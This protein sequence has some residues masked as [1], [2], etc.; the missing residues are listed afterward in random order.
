MPKI[1]PQ[2]VS[3]TPASGTFTLNAQTAIR[4]PAGQEEIRR[5]GQYLSDRL[6]PATGFPLP[7]KAISGRSASGQILLTTDHADPALGDEGYELSV[8]RGSVR[9]SAPQP[10]GL[11]HGVQTLRQLFPAS[12]ESPEPAAG[13]WML[14]AC[15]VR[16]RPRFGWRGAMLDVA[17]HFFDPAAVRRFIDQMAYYKL[18]LLHLHLSDDQG[19]RLEIQSH[20]DLAVKGGACSV[21]FESNGYY[22]QAEY[23]DLVEYARQRYITILPEIDMPGHTNAVLAA[24]PEL[25]PD[26]KAPEPYPGTEVGFSS[27]AIHQENTYAFLEDVIRELAALTPG[28]YLHIGGDEAHS[29]PEPDYIHFVQRVQQIVKAHGKMCIGWEEVAKAELLPDTVVQFW[30]NKDWARKG[31]EQGRKFMLSPATHAYMDI[32][33]DAETLLGQDWTKVYIPVKAAYEW[34]P[35]KMLEGVGEKSILGVEAPLWSETTVTTADLDYMIFPRL[36]GYAEIAWSPKGPR[37][38]EEYRQ[39]LAGHGPRMA[40]MGIHFYRSPQVDWD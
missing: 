29:T 30:W 20:P 31:A 5:I 1:I 35:T 18:N 16:D 39:R 4:V 26:G 22:T 3:V 14:E 27:F 33:Y 15:L 38:W 10:A 19:W 17:R 34:E 13:P 2:P 23:K 24:L 28:A 11:F 6:R 36:P 7:V 40:A 9:L 25:N 37:K 32:K 8:E 12:I 21:K